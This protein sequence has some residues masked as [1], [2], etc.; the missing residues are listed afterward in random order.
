MANDDERSGGWYMHTGADEANLLKAKVKSA[1]CTHKNEDDLYEAYEGSSVSKF[2]GAE[3]IDRQHSAK[4]AKRQLW[5]IVVRQ[6]KVGSLITYISTNH[7][8]DGKG[9]LDY[10]VGCFAAGVDK[11]KLKATDKQ[12]LT[13]M[14]EGIPSGATAEEAVAILT[15]MTNL[16]DSLKDTK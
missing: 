14:R 1:I 16:R 11:L 8:D 2:S 10:I 13:Y 9:A 3:P 7:P 6:I 4:K 5:A 15:K 12:Y